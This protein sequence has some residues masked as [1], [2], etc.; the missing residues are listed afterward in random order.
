M[1]CE[2]F[3]MIS[4]YLFQPISPWLYFFEWLYY[5]SSYVC[6]SDIMFLPILSNP[7]WWPWLH[8][9]WMIII[10]A[11]KSTLS[12][13]NH[14]CVLPWVEPCSNSKRWP[15]TFT[16]KAR[17]VLLLSLSCLCHATHV[18]LQHV[19]HA[20]VNCIN[21]TMHGCNNLFGILQ[22]YSPS[23]HMGITCIWPKI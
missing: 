15:N 17:L 20:I 11:Y 18:S 3:S 19:H 5:V 23:P 21:W 22:K 2:L 6:S 10:R 4:S 9:F 1:Q 7:T 13:H 16:P 8:L 12:E 14:C